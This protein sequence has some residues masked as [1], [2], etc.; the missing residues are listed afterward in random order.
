MS[1]ESYSTTVDQFILRLQ[2]LLRESA[3]ETGRSP[4]RFYVG[5]QE[6][7]LIQD[8]AAHRPELFYSVR[9]G[10]R[11]QVR[12]RIVGLPVYRVDADSHLACY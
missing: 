11:D 3:L 1:D 5:R 8:W 7:E 12:Y 2:R 6:W 10:A 4:T 9:E